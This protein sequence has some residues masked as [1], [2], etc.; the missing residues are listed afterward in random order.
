MTKLDSIL[1]S[2]DITLPTKVRVVKAMVFPVVMYG[3]QSWTVKKAEHRRIDAFELWCWR[4]LLRVPWTARRSNQSI[5][6][7]SPGCSL[8]G[9]MLKLKLQYFGHLIDSLGKTLMLGGIWGRRRRGRQRTR[10]LD[11]NTDLMDVS[12]CELQELV[13]DREAWRAAIHGVAKSR[14]RL[15]RL[16]SSSS[17]SSIFFSSGQVLLST[18][19]WCS[20][21]TSV[22]EDVFLMYPWR[23]KCS[24]PTYSSAIFF[25]IWL[26]KGFLFLTC[27]QQ[28]TTHDAME[29]V[30]V[31]CRI[32]GSNNLGA[33]PVVNSSRSRRPTV[34]RYYPLSLFHDPSEILIT[35]V[36]NT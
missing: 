28:R 11:G 23:E 21:C 26:F 25:C 5:L 35:A 20:V 14:T 22:S 31:S 13:M 33:K 7:I 9:M 8:E 36:M 24:M 3:C 12:L 27:G 19:S 32:R 16:S 4:R 1:K 29:S 2:R 34:S 30:W 10:W 6:K 17:S 15:K 18:H